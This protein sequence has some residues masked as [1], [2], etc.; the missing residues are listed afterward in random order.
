MRVK[1]S[2]PSLEKDAPEWFAE[3][4]PAPLEALKAARIWSGLSGLAVVYV[5]DWVTE[6]KF[7]GGGEV[8]RSTSVPPYAKGLG[9][10]GNRLLTNLEKAVAGESLPLGSRPQATM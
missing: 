7:S 5:S 1:V 9:N 3:L 4:L 10:L 2:P 8:I 6:G